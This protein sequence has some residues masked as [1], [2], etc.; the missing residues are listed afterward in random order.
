MS[1]SYEVLDGKNC[2]LW[3]RYLSSSH[4]CNTKINREREI[5][6]FDNP[7]FII[8]KGGSRPTATNPATER[9]RH[10]SSC[11]R[12]IRLHGTLCCMVSWS[13]YRLDMVAIFFFMVV[14]FHVM[15]VIYRM[16][17][18]VSAFVD[19]DLSISERL[20]DWQQTRETFQCTTVWLKVTRVEWEARRACKAQSIPT[21]QRALQDKW[22]PQ[23]CS[24]NK[25][26]QE[27]RTYKGD[28]YHDQPGD[29]FQWNGVH[30][31]QWRLV[32]HDGTIFSEKN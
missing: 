4:R 16:A 24:Q 3:L 31:R 10:R 19:F 30:G 21:S 15:V 18:V 22:T 2:L 23:G 11:F 29:R 32:A 13:E 5:P 28:E 12:K 1:I 20:P 27:L 6:R 25:H 14:V 17:N 8:K 7:H 26:F 9:S